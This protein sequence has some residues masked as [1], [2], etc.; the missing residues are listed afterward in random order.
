MVGM[1]EAGNHHALGAFA[2]EMHIQ[3]AI[4]MEVR[5]FGTAPREAH[6][7]EA[8]AAWSDARKLER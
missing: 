7:T 3:Q 1:C 6:A 5:K 2:G 8:M 4:S